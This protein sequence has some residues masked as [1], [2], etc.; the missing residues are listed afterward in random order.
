MQAKPISQNLQ[1]LQLKVEHAEHVKKIISQINAAANLDQILL[2]LH[3][4]ILSLFDAEDLTLFAFDSE[5]KEIFSKVP[6]VDSVEEL[7]IPI[8][9]QSLAGFCAKYLRPVNIV[10]AKT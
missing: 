1:E 3:K 5:K 9:E 6:H 10:D 8:T 7:R 4:D 2:D